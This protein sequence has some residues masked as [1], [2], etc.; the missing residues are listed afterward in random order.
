MM[1]RITVAPAWEWWLVWYFFI[2]GLAAGLYCTAALFELMGTARD[3][4]MAKVSDYLA[5]PLVLVCA[6]LLILDLGRPARFHH[7]HVRERMSFFN[8]TILRSSIESPTAPQTE[9]QPLS[10]AQKNHP[11][12]LQ[13][14]AAG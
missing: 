1:A 7:I 2:G 14:P 12:L 4:E 11:K 9:F 10:P 13:A 3:R 6:V 5:F 8:R